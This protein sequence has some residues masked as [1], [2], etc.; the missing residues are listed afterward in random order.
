MTWIQKMFRRKERHI[1]NNLPEP[2]IMSREALQALEEEWKTRFSER[3]APEFKKI[4]PYIVSVA[5][6]FSTVEKDDD[7]WKYPGL[8]I[9]D[10]LSQNN[11]S[12]L[13]RLARDNDTTYFGYKILAYNGLPWEKNVIFGLRYPAENS[14]DKKE[15]LYNFFRNFQ[16]GSQG[17]HEDEATLRK[18]VD[19]FNI[20]L[21]YLI[22]LTTETVEDLITMARKRGATLS[23]ARGFTLKVY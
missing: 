5:P 16:R 9:A 17:S 21:D 19:V 23:L 11:F 4:S 15:Y 20:K 1:F 12:V 6:G 22:P 7:W 13:G 10:Q 8:E 3:Y 2:I 14:L 18:T